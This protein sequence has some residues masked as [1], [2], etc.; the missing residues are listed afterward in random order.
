[1]TNEER[2]RIY[3]QLAAPF[4]ESAIQ[5]T[6]GRTTGKGYSTTGIGY[7]HIVN[8]LNEVLGIG[9]WRAHREITI[10]EITTAS[11]RKAYEAICDLVLELGEW[12]NGDF[13]VFAEALADGGHTSMSEAD[14]RKGG[15]TNSLKKAAA[16]FGCGR[17]AY[18]GTLDDDNLPAE[19]PPPMPEPV[20][21]T[22][23]QTAQVQAPAA[24]QQPVV[25]QP[26]AQASPPPSRNRLTSKQLAA[27]W[28]IAR[29]LEMEQSAVR[30]WSKQTWNS[31]PEFLTRDQASQAISAL[32][33][34]QGNG[35]APGAEAEL[36]AVG[37]E[38]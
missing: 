20:R 6:D 4:P 16:M 28:A 2:K 12:S 19:V 33:A 9:G 5:R 18:E 11:G 27:I 38:G 13:I 32:T 24:T 17:Q 21:H 8:R 7:Q 14:A 29:K 10:R 1:M 26:R 30:A 31:Q 37:Q 25:Q 36:R 3:Q 34:R 35:H 22:P 23:Q 15:Y